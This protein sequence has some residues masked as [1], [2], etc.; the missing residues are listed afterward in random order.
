[1]VVEHL[2]DLCSGANIYISDV[3]LT[4]DNTHDT[5]DNLEFFMIYKY[6][7]CWKLLKKSAYKPQNK[8]SQAILPTIYWPIHKNYLFVDQ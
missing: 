3:W 2:S 8:G 4:H 6:I 1:M 5:H 7:N